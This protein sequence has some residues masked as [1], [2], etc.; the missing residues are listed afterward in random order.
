MRVQTSFEKFAQLTHGGLF[1]FCLMALRILLGVA[2]L[3]LA[4]AVPLA[5]MSWLH[6]VAG[7]VG[8][9]FL[10]GLVVRPNALLGVVALVFVL[11]TEATNLEGSVK[12]IGLM[13]LLGLF[14][15]G[16][17]SHILGL[18]G[19]ILRNLRRPGRVARFLFG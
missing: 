14:A 19:L 10:A 5:D 12:I 7:V 18:D 17:S 4:T 1:A 8:L 15:A 16:G 3:G 2:A 6:A 13:L 11:A 9:S